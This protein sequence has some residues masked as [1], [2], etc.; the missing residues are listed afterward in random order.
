MRQAAE[1]ANLTVSGAT[2]YEFQPH[3]ITGIII[4]PA[5]T[6]SV[7]T[8]PEYGVVCADINSR[9]SQIFRQLLQ[10]IREE[11][12]VSLNQVHNRTDF[13]HNGLVLRGVRYHLMTGDSTPALVLA[14]ET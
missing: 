7:H 6:M 3:G 5:F 1:Y 11:L 8:W 4:G 13:D 9:N 10:T 2:F 12:G 14:T